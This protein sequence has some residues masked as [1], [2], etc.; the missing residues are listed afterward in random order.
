MSYAGHKHFTIV[1]QWEPIENTVMYQKGVII[2]KNMIEPRPFSNSSE[3][4]VI[5][6]V[7]IYMSFMKIRPKLTALERSQNLLKI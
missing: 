3:S 4:L 2:L 7:I 6:T 1:R 5:S